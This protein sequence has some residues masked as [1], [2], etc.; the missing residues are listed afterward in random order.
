MLTVEFSRGRAVLGARAWRR[1]VRVWA[2]DGGA[3]KKL[4]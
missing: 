3:R 4:D 1:P 2:G